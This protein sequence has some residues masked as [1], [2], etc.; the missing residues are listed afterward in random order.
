MEIKNGKK[1]KNGQGVGKDI[2][3][4]HEEEG[5]SLHSTIQEWWGPPHQSSGL[6]SARPTAR[7]PTTLP[8]ATPTP[9]TPPMPFGLADRP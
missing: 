5:G 9:I 7:E 3:L 1:R 8:T 6:M 4:P 2:R